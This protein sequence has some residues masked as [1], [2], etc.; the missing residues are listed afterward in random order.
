LVKAAHLGKV[1][2]G[3]L[4]SLLQTVIW[5]S[6]AIISFAHLEGKKEIGLIGEPLVTSWE[7]H[8]V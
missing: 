3:D 1:E 8:H 2:I 7:T 4:E 6:K 5:L